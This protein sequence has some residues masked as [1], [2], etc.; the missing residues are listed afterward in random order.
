MNLKTILLNAAI[1]VVSGVISLF[2]MSSP[3][4]CCCGVPLLICVPLLLGTTLATLLTSGRTAALNNTM[5]GVGHGLF[6]AA[7]ATGAVMIGMNQFTSDEKLI[8]V[9]AEYRQQWDEVQ[10]TFHEAAEREQQ[11]ISET[12]REQMD[13]L[14]K[15]TRDTLE[16]M[17]S[18]PDLTRANVT[19]SFGLFALLCGLL[20]GAVG[21]FAGHLIFG[22]RRRPADEEEPPGESSDPDRMRIPEQPK[23]WWDQ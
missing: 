11:E 8:S 6:A 23:Q 16:R 17:E 19:R 3:G 5:C 9:V 15:V 1:G 22:R 12:E 21:G 7:L 10:E 4:A 18:D 2:C 20:L 13:E 14:F